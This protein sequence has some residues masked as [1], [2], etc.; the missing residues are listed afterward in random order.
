MKKLIIINDSL[1]N[2]ISYYLLAA[3]LIALPFQ[4]FYSE[5]L[6]TCFAIHTL[7]HL[8]KSRLKALKDKR[9]WIISSIFFVSL[10]AIFYS[11]YIAEGSKDVV[12][13]LGILLFPVC[14]SVTNIDVR[15]YQF[16]L[17]KIFAVTCTVI[18]VYLYIYAFHVIQYFHFP[19]LAIFNKEFINQNFSAPI[20]L[21]STYLSMYVALSISIFL[22]LFFKNPGLKNSKNILFSVVL[23]AGLIQLSSRSVFIAM[24]VIFI[25][26]IPA[27]LLRGK[28]RLHFSVISSVVFLVLVS[29]IVNI[30]SF[31]KRY[32]SDFE[33]DL[34]E[35]AVT[36]DLTETR[37]KRWLSDLELIRQSPW[38]G[39][40]SGSEK[41]VLKDKY[42]EEKFYRSYL[43]ELNA[44]NQYLSFLI[45]NG[46]VG[47]LLYLYVLLYGFSRA[48]EKRHFLLLAFLIL[49]AVVSVSENILDVNKGIFFY[50]FFFSLFLLTPNE[51]IHSDLPR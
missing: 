4:H 45:K 42:F 16:S 37:M 51:K 36:P 28:E 18:V 40:G 47:L 33:D 46:I 20:E 9:V 31:R 30:D 5:I 26:A 11:N 3:F 21:H 10:F 14:L 50:S 49:I 23:F 43:F 17:L 13:Q 35:S 22:F 29:A 44:H 24:C 27:L 1:D 2:R 38:I 48:I 25:I 15:K 12:H 34:S 6:L 19:L 32:V 39:Y 41:Q 8:K 7:I